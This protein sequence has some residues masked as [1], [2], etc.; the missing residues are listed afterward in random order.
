MEVWGGNQVSDQEIK[1][2]GLDIWVYSKPYAESSDGG[3]VYYLSSCAS[4]RI[5][6][7]LLA[8]VSGHGKRVAPTAEFLR[9]LMRKNINH[10][11]QASLVNQLND[12]FT[13]TTG[14]TFATALV[15]TYFAPTKKLSISSAGHHSPFIYRNSQKRWEMLED[16]LTE[17]T[18]KLIRNFPLG[19]KKDTSYSDYKIDL[20]Q[21]DMILYF[22][23][24]LFE[25]KQED[26]ELLGTKGLLK[27]LSDIDTAEPKKVASQIKSFISKI[28]SP[29]SSDDISMILMSRN[30][31]KVSLKDNLMA[32]VFLVR[33]LV[34]SFKNRKNLPGI[35]GK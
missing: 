34:K 16:S 33:S 24:G 8:D 3:D 25:I 21:G 20:E 32:P 10:V 17:S 2:T 26:G 31:E 30:H 12:D 35:N 1:T 14:S 15:S 23:D 19:V 4:G 5:T 11:K 9:N 27:V 22:T 18:E 29:K 13:E 6:R 28:T 7:I